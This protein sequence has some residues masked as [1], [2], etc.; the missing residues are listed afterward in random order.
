MEPNPEASENLEGLVPS[1]IVGIGASAGG[2]EAIEQFFRN[3][4][5]DTGMAFVIVQHLS[6]DFKSLMSEVMARWT[7]MPI[8]TADDRMKVWANRVYLMPPKVEM[9]ISNGELLLKARERLDTLRL[10]IDQFFRS[11]ARDA[12]NK[13]IGIILSGTGSDGSRGI[14]DIHDAGGLVLAQREETAKFDGMPKSAIETGVVDLILPPEEMPVEL[15]RKVRRIQAPSSV[16]ATPPNL[17]TPLF[18]LLR[19]AYGIDFSYY[20]PS[21]V[22]RRIERR[23]QISRIE[24]LESYVSKLRTDRDELDALYRDLLIGVTSFFRDADAFEF[25]EKDILP[26]LL[27]K[28]AQGED[29]RV[30]VAGCATGEEAYSLGILILEE[31][32][33][34]GKLVKPKIFATDAHPH[35]LE[36]AALGVYPPEAVAGL[37]AARLARH[38]T[39]VAEGYKVNQELRNLVVFVK[40]NII[41]DAPF[42]R[43]NLISCR[44]LL[45]YLLPSAQKKATSL[46]HFGLKSGGVLFLGPSET[47]GDLS[48]EFEPINQRWKIF[49]KLRDAK[50]P[51]DFKMRWPG[52]SLRAEPSSGASQNLA[53]EATL[54]D[55]L[56]RM[57]EETQPAGI[58]V[59][60]SLEILH[61][62]GEASRF[63]RLAKGVPSLSLLEL[64]PDQLRTAVGA[65]IHRA[66]RDKQKVSFSGIPYQGAGPGQVLNIHVVPIGATKRHGPCLLV[67]FEEP[68]L[69]K[70]DPV[71]PFPLDVHKVTQEQ[72]EALEAE[73][74]GTKENLQATIEELETTN[75]EL[76]ATNEELLASNEELQSTNEELHSVNEELFTV[77]AEYQRKIHQ[78]TELSNDMDNL[79]SSTDV[80]TMFLDEG[81]CIRKFTPR[82]GEVFNLIP[83]DIGRKIHG[84][85]HT[86]SCEN[87]TV[88]LNKVLTKGEIHEEEVR[89]HLGAN[90]FMRILPYKGDPGRAGVVLT[91]IDITMVKAAENRF[92]NAIEVSPNGMLMVDSNG[93]ITLVNTEL[94]RIFGYLPGE[95]IGQ[96]MEI[97]VE[98]GMVMRHMELRNHY[99]QNP[100][101]LRRMGGDTDVMGRRKDG[102]TIP[103]EIRVNPIQT[104]TGTQAIASVMDISHHRKLQKALREQVEKRDRFL[105]TLSH[106]LRNP[107][108]AILTASSLL[109]RVGQENQEIAQPCDIIQRH[110]AQIATLLDDL[111]DVS[112]VTQGK[113]KLR[114]APVE[115]QSVCRES[116]EAIAGMARN[117]RHQV[118]W[119]EGPQPIWVEG[120][121]VRLLQIL[122]NLLSNAIKYTPEGGVIQVEATQSEGQAILK[123]RDNG[124]GIA[125]EMIDSIF[126]MFVQSDDTLDR[127]EG[128]MG[129]GLTLVKSLVEL[130]GG[131]VKAISAGK[132]AG[133]EFVVS[134][135]MTVNRPVNLGVPKEQKP[136][137]PIKIVLVEDNRDAREMLETLLKLENYEVAESA[138]DGPSGLEAVLKHRPHAALLDIGLPGMDGYQLARRIRAE[139]GSSIRL[140]ALTGYGRGEDQEAV[141]AAGFD[142]H[143]VKPV[144]I[145]RLDQALKKLC[146]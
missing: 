64:L 46:L 74:R 16:P 37:S 115:L 146:S 80:H 90:Y 2:L 45:I 142:E 54:A 79:L 112:R 56:I 71:T 24:D 144:Q 6:P 124:C 3:M 97:L 7:A 99:F 55:I 121:R 85:V 119:T 86:I 34:T 10:P 92:R 120:D 101:M 4:P 23:L 143:L 94:E 82:M 58:L 100:Y 20:K 39:Q 128:G 66:N 38:F 36:K 127:S 15:L 52:A 5:D 27:E 91:L 113:I 87:L 131:S 60:P 29:F 61:T 75:E 110:S 89:N 137:E 116:I 70:T 72:I 33:K 109:S 59:N 125:A 42:T 17:L 135:P 67:Q 48:P 78:L 76:Q 12:S 31:M 35:S 96:P 117:R 50:L 122:E 88:K 28:A 32:E 11:L 77:N 114:S 53:R 126:D 41:R 8:F 107:M 14:R 44:N 95:L 136:K 145:S 40:H 83:S 47:P 81:M 133:S 106:E 18:A 49:Q 22:D 139:L 130:H 63:L 69:P 84:F 57:V 43:V 65:A 123:V 141:L 132:G 140:I 104:P 111:L 102:Q 13:S 73:L 108:A 103:L 105:A 51:P 118:V 25:L 138:C 19:E 26:G 68:V 9:I 98:A 129:V 93:R 1:H 21:T 30:W 62:F 134:L